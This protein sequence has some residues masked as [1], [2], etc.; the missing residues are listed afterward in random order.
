VAEGSLLWRELLVTDLVC[1]F[2]AGWVAGALLML[3]LSFT[4]YRQSYYYK[5][6]QA[7]MLGEIHKP[8]I[9]SRLVTM[10]VLLVMV[11]L[12]ALF[13]LWIS[14]GESY[15]FAFLF[16][17]NLLL[18][19]LLSLFDALFIDLFLL[20]VWRPVL[21]RLPEGQPTRDYMSRHIKLQFTAGWIF[22]VPIALLAAAFSFIL[23]AGF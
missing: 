16:A 20:L 8:G 5:K 19:F 9:L 21:L 10:M 11:L 13:D 14:S 17:L 22:K 12:L 6:A 23:S 3:L 15:S 7:E 18:V 1:K 4:L 2:L